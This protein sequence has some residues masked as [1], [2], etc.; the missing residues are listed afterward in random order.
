MIGNEVEGLSNTRFVRKPDENAVYRVELENVNDVTTKF[1]DWVEKDFLD[2]DKWNI[3]QVTFDNYEIKDGR[4]ESSAKQ[5]L[6]YNNSE[7]NLIGSSLGESEEI[8]KEKLDDMKDAFDDLEIIDVEKKPEILAS[9][10]VK[11]VNS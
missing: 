7:W 9:S 5:I 4:I 10:F 11:G 2:L 1:V 3:K 8:N 6:D